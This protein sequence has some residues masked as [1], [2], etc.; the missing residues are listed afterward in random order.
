MI[1]A[2]FLGL[3]ATPVV[4][5]VMEVEGTQPPDVAMITGALEKEIG[6]R[7]A[8]AVVTMHPGVGCGEPDRCAEAMA[9]AAGT[10]EVFLLRMIQGP[11]SLR[12][13]A[14]RYRSSLE[15]LS[16]TAALR[17]LDLE[18]TRVL[19]VLR[20][21][22]DSLL[23]FERRPELTAPPAQLSLAPPPEPRIWPWWV[24]GVGVVAGGVAVGLAAAAPHHFQ[25][26]A[27]PQALSRAE[28]DAARTNG[29][30]Q[31]EVSGGL[32]IGAVGLLGVALAGFLM[33]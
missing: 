7:L 15:L 1:G 5:S 3:I 10:D 19:E 16:A 25:G 33:E 11:L 26:V 18:P 32:A 29:D 2:F 31:R 6:V 17:P 22:L 21:M 30:V 20:P 23:V 24:A 14:L 27:V 28:L 13:E 4:L 9:R 12:V 8:R